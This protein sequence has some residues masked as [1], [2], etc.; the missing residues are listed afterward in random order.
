MAAKPR[1]ATARGRYAAVMTE[2]LKK[3][4][5]PIFRGLINLL[6]PNLPAKYALESIGRQS[7]IQ[8]SELSSAKLGFDSLSGEQVNVLCDLL[9]ALVYKTPSLKEAR[10]LL[11]RLE[12]LC[13]PLEAPKP[14]ATQVLKPPEEVKNNVG[15]LP[16]LIDGEMIFSESPSPVVLNF[17]NRSVVIN[18]DCTLKIRG[19]KELTVTFP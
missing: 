13:D 10:A 1:K 8:F 2:E 19:Q 3:N 7:E 5:K 16:T 17:G 18:G 6:A 15:A 11:G 12:G 9:D 14:A 4:R